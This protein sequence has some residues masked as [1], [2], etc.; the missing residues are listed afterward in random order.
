MTVLSRLTERQRDWDLRFLD[1][2]SLVGSWSK[3][4]STKV[5]AAIVRRD[6]TVASVGYNGFPKYMEDKPDGYENRD[7]KL[8]RIVHAEMNAILHCREPV[9]G[10]TLYTTPLMPC[11]RCASFIAQSGINRVVSVPNGN[12]RWKESFEKTVDI[13]G[14]CGVELVLYPEKGEI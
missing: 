12:E 11:D 13:F 4:P 6:M 14:Q 3:D 8:S 10:Y 2:A 7:Y 9:R 5:G 1:L